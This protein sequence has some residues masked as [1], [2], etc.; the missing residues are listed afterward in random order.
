[1]EQYFAKF[2]KNII[3]KDVTINTPYGDNKTSSDNLKY[4]M[5]NLLEMSLT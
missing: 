5:D 4:K 3:G 2:K 1:M